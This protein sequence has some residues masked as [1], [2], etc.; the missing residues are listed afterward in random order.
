M[1]RRRFLLLGTS[2]VLLL[3]L[4]G[5]LGYLLQR[6]G[7]PISQ[8]GCDRIKPGMSLAEVEAILGR[9]AGDYH[10]PDRPVV[11]NLLPR[12]TPGL[13]QKVWIGNAGAVVV[14]FDNSDRV[15]RVHFAPALNRDEG[16]LEMLRRW[17]RL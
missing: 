4:V 17:L 7:S 2:G 8:A 11:I 13:V 12:P 5:G 6:T 3:A 10:D 9:R 15:M 16:F 14:H 1:N